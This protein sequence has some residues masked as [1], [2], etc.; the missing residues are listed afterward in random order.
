MERNMRMCTKIK[1]KSRPDCFQTFV[2]SVLKVFSVGCEDGCICPTHVMLL[3]CMTI[4]SSTVFCLLLLTGNGYSDI[5]WPEERT[6]S[7]LW[8]S[9]RT[10]GHSS[11][12]YVFY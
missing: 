9:H 3:G 1:R 12:L 5:L 7:H 6:E 4:I 2:V 8:L 11:Y 10:S